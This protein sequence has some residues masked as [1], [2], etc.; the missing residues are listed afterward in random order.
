MISSYAVLAPSR[1]TTV[2]LRCPSIEYQKVYEWSPVVKDL[3]SQI[4]SHFQTTLNI[5]K[6]QKYC[7]GNAGIYLH[8]DKILD[9]NP[10]TDSAFWDE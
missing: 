9:L 10:E 6:I 3:T 4:E 5:A 2:W 1:V 8:A 7:D